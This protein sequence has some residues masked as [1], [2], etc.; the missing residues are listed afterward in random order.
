MTLVETL[1][2]EAGDEIVIPYAKYRLDNGLT[3]ILHEDASDPLV[4]VD[5]T[6]HVGS[7]REEVGKS[8]F[9]HFFEHMMFQGS[10]NVGDEQHFK[11]V[12]ESGGTLNG[13]TNVDRT[14]YFRPCRPTSWRRC[15]GSKRTA[16]A[17]CS[18][19]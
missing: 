16:W 9:A 7:A 18:M 11:I 8:G 10:S 3:V 13:T 2:R 17:F 15:C 5:V 4:H 1:A 6:Y 12:S 14:N 19:P